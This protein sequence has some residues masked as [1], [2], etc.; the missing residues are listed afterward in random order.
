VATVTR[1]INKVNDPNRFLKIS[2]DNFEKK[3]DE[4]VYPLSMRVAPHGFYT[5]RTEIPRY[6]IRH[7][8]KANKK[9]RIVTNFEEEVV[10]LSKDCDLSSS[11]SD[12]HSEG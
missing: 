6:E 1:L 12:E 3:Y 7:S 5:S 8:S 4:D 10:E 11:S 9:K 2:Y